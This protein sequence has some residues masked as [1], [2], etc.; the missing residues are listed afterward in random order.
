MIPIHDLIFFII[1][2]FILVISP[3]P[4][5]IYLI[6]RTITQGRKAGLTSLAGVVCGFLFHIVMVS[7]GLTAV[8]FAVPYAYVVL[9]TLGT[10]YLL[11]L[12]YQAIKPNSKNIFEVDRNISID[13]PRKLFTVG[14]LTNVLNPKVAVFYLSFFPQFIKPQYGS[15]F[16][17]SLELGIIQVF[18][19][20]SINFIIVLTAAQV[21]RFFAKNPTWIKAQKWFMASVLGFLA[22]KM[23]LSKAK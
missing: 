15:I 1:A 11:Y 17:Q 5:M 6:S 4:N 3:G 9:K 8:L 18:V 20:F 14:F 7:F 22:I 19:S 16:T 2:A 13:R 10:V 12:A 21:A 23:A